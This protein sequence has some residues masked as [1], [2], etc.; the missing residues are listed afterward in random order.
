MVIPLSVSAVFSF[1]PLISNSVICISQVAY[2]VKKF[3]DLFSVCLTAK[4]DVSFF[5]TIHLF[6]ASYQTS[7]LQPLLIL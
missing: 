4:K 2:V 6:S 5:Q 7:T 3:V 1:C